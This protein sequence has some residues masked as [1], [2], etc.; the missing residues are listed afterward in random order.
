MNNI[1]RKIRVWWYW[2]KYDVC[3]VHLSLVRSGGG[4]EPHWICD[5]CDNENRIKNK[6]RSARYLQERDQALSKVKELY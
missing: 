6:D 3:P 1:F 5:K 4:Y 2:R